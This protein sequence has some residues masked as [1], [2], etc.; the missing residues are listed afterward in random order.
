M[1]FEE[2]SIKNMVLKN[3]IVRSATHEGMSD[4]NGFP[5]PK[6]FKCYEKLAKGGVGLIITGLS[7]VS[8][9]GKNCFGGMQGIDS[10]QHVPKYQELVDFVHEQG[11][12]ICMQ[13]AHCG[14]QT[15]KTA[16]GTDPIAPSPVKDLSMLSKPRKMSEDDIERIIQAFVNAVRRVKE[17]GFDAVQLHAAHGYLLNQFLCP[18]TNRRKDRWGGSI[19][20]RMR[21]ISEIYERSRKI[22]GEDYPIL[23]KIN[24]TDNMKNGLKIDESLVMAQMIDAMG[25]D[26]IEISCGIGEDGLSTMRGELPFHA[27]LDDWDMFKNLNPVFRLILRKTSKWFIKSVPFTPAY[28]LENARYIKEK[29]NIPVF[30]V[31]GLTNKPLMEKVLDDGDADYISLCRSLIFDPRW[32]EKIKNGS[33]ENCRCINCNLCIIYLNQRPLKCYYGKQLPAKAS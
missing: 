19:E 13:V 23:I 28:N 29:V 6:L 5:T 3:R 20:N 25:F 30:L 16:I 33:I 27:M 15:T 31:G 22:V 14:R 11:S 2:S 7:F 8:Q 32:P 9:D 17:S 12:K 10:D 4:E 26:G 21:I 1:L 24:A 18:H